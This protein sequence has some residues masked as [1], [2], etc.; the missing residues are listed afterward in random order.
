MIRV[1]SLVGLGVLE[2]LELK[3]GATTATLVVS[4]DVFTLALRQFLGGTRFALIPQ[5]V[6]FLKRMPQK[7]DSTAIDEFGTKG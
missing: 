7:I 3:T 6:C 4:G 1:I 2:F 5:S